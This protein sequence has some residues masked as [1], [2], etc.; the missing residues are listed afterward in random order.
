V[1]VAADPVAHELADDAESVLLDARLHGVADVAQVVARAA[2]LDGVEE[3]RARGGQQALR[4]RR[5]VADRD[6]DRRV[7]DPAVEDHADVDGQDVAAA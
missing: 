6:G 5:D 7:G 3:R 1:H 2:L 4:D